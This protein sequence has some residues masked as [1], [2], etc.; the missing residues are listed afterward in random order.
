MAASTIVSVS[1]FG[2][3]DTVSINGVCFQPNS[4]LPAVIIED[5][6]NSLFLYGA[7]ALKERTGLGLSDQE[8]AG[9]RMPV[10]FLWQQLKSSDNLGVKQLAAH[11]IAKYVVKLVCECYPQYLLQQAS[12]AADSAPSVAFSNTGANRLPLINKAFLKA[13]C[14][15]VLCI[16]DNFDEVEQQCLLNAFSGFELRLLWRSI[17]CLLGF[18][19]GVA[20]APQK[21]ANTQAPTA[22]K[23]PLT[24]AAPS[25]LSKVVSNNQDVAAGI[26][27]SSALEL[28]PADI[29]S[30]ALMRQVYVLYLGPDSIDLSLYELKLHSDQQYVIPVRLKPIY[31][32]CALPQGLSLWQ[33]ALSAAAFA[34]NK[35]PLTLKQQ[36]D[37]RV[38]Q[39]LLL[40]L[41]FKYPE[42]WL[43]QSPLGTVQVLRVPEA[44]G[45]NYAWLYTQQ[46]L[47]TPNDS[48]KLTVDSNALTA[49]THAYELKVD[50]SLAAYAPAVAQPHFSRFSKEVPAT[51]MECLLQEVLK[52]HQQHTP[53]LVTGPQLNHHA[54]FKL[55]QQ[56]LQ[57]ANIDVTVVPWTD[58]SLGGVV[59][60][61]RLDYNDPELYPTYLDRLRK[62]SMVITNSDATDYREKVLID[63]QQE[64]SPQYEF[65]TTQLLTIQAGSNCIGLYVSHD[66]N[67]NDESIAKATTVSF[68]DQGISVQSAEIPFRSGK[69]A[70]QNEPVEITVRQ[71]ALSG[72]TKIII[73]PLGPS[74][75]LPPRG[76]IQDFDPQKKVDFTGLL[77]VL[78]R[79]YPPLARP[80][81]LAGRRRIN[82]LTR[83]NTLFSTKKSA[84]T[85]SLVYYDQQFASY[86]Y[87]KQVAK[88]LET[89]LITHGAVLRFALNSNNFKRLNDELKNCLPLPMYRPF[90]Q[91]RFNQIAAII[92]KA[93]DRAL[94]GTGFKSDVNNLLGKECDFVPDRAQEVG[95]CCTH[96]LHYYNQYGIFNTAIIS[97]VIT[98]VE[99]HPQCFTPSSPQFCLSHDLALALSNSS[100]DLI[101]KVIAELQQVA[102]FLQKQRLTGK[103]MLSYALMSLLYA[104]LYRKKDPTFL[105]DEASLQKWDEVLNSVLK[106][107][108]SLL[109]LMRSGKYRDYVDL[110]V[111]KSFMDNVDSFIAS[112]LEPL[113]KDVIK[114]L[115][116]EG[117]NPNIMAELGQLEDENEGESEVEY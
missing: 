46:S 16:P 65:N 43:Q 6:Q 69:T 24:A 95:M 111:S 17:A 9:A 110:L 5:R 74:E 86:A 27:A 112:K 11:R 10:S 49:F 60:Q 115:H 94:N 72:Y 87:S 7:A 35:L 44:Q 25:G 114:Y 39:Q 100:Y 56:R 13:N 76:E 53:V 83:N 28:L 50:E 55:L 108:R 40:Q 81:H 66:P 96:L 21:I 75:V 68:K 59:F 33:Y 18:F 19:N 62:L 63:D 51:F 47:L 85:N 64:I 78:S 117:S 104:L 99:N 105:N 37:T 45:D 42:M 101:Q 106:H 89:D 90:G 48:I 15:L 29:T 36:H 92:S 103:N 14:R 79:A 4:S 82:K 41:V 113:I 67:F 107:Y 73:R 31:D 12:V 58:L 22:A 1:A 2:F 54:F 70:P 34:L 61:Q 88:R 52:R 102:V 93:V 91:E 3:A 109:S 20:A 32:D 116:K 77:P 57:A 80:K 8:S 97:R 71:K 98:L 38:R 84:S 23:L 30:L 26:L